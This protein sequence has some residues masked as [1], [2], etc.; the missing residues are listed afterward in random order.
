MFFGYL[1]PLLIEGGETGV[2]A[3]APRQRTVLA[4]LLTRAGRPVAVDELAEFVWDGNPSDRAADTLRT[5]VMRLRR[6]L[7]T[8]AGARIVTRDPGYLIEAAD[9]EVD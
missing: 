1:G 9:D 3:L 4:V 6:A 2:T 5:Y 7:G 8:A